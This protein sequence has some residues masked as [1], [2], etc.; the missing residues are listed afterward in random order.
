MIFTAIPYLGG[1]LIPAV[2]R[3]LELDPETV[4]LALQQP[5]E[6]YRSWLLQGNPQA[7]L[8][9]CGDYWVAYR[10][11]MCGVLRVLALRHS[12]PSML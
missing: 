12:P 5:P 7:V 9:A 8:G 11:E 6:P 4:T 10:V 2:I 1:P 3:A